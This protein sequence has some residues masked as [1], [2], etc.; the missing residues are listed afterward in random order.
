M[1]GNT[2]LKLL[3]AEDLQECGLYFNLEYPQ[4]NKSYC[5]NLKALTHLNILAE[6]RLL[7][8]KALCDRV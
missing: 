5:G 2:R 6:T 3:S 7:R 4:N 8:E 1:A